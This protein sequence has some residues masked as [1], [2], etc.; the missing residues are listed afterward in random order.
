[1]RACLESAR[2]PLE[3]ES[4]A[5]LVACLASVVFFAALGAPTVAAGFV[6]RGVLEPARSGPGADAFR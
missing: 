1:L 5:F 6:A 2:F 3:A 4:A